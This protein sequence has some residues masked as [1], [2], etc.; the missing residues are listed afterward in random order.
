MPISINFNY[1]A[2][3][4]IN[5]LLYPYAVTPGL[6]CLVFFS[7]FQ[8]H[9]I[10]NKKHNFDQFKV[11]PGSIAAM[12]GMKIGD[13]I[14]RINQIPTTNM[15]HYEAHIVLANA[16]NQFV[17]GVLRAK[18]V[19]PSGGPPTSTASTPTPHTN[20]TSSSPPT[21]V[22]VAMPTKIYDKISK[23]ILN[24]ATEE[25]EINTIIPDESLT[26]EQIAE[27]MSCEVQ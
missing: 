4:V 25:E 13:V 23:K 26:D 1:F 5:E 9:Y 10:S 11:V 6:L 17:L 19:T 15:S 16:G 14:V 3:L 27:M 22:P 12:T 8:D 2:T 24:N 21:P 20:G 18:D 7:Y